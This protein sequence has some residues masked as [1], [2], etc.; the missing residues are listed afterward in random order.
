METW[1]TI[2]GY[3]GRYE[4]SSL[5]RVRSYAKGEP[6]LLSVV[7]CGK[8]PAVPLSKDGK[9]KVMY[10][11]TL[12]MLAFVGPRPEGKEIRHRDGNKM[13]PHRRNLSYG[14]KA[15]NMIDRFRHSLSTRKVSPEKIALVR[16]LYSRPVAYRQKDVAMWL[17]VT[18][19]T[20]TRIKVGSGLYGR[21]RAYPHERSI[22][23]IEKY[24]EAY[25]QPAPILQ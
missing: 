12:V 24:R 3:E 21:I 23:L 10:L 13:N 2:P 19:P 17:G 16:G 8:Y 18:S 5:G 11:H 7:M 6:R 22:A 15:E 25:V 20:I 9:A 4:V 14:T 1:K